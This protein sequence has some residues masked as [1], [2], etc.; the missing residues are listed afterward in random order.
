M[1]ILKWAGIMSVTGASRMPPYRLLRLCLFSLAILTLFVLSAH[2]LADRTCAPTTF[3]SVSCLTPTDF[4]N[5]FQQHLS[6]CALHLG[7][8]LPMLAIWAL[9]S[10]GLLPYT[11]VT[12][13]RVQQLLLLPF[14][15]PKLSSTA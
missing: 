9:P 7:I 10:I 8:V 2:L 12:P 13:A 1:N 3:G 4:A 6:H 5:R 11:P 14:L 15:P